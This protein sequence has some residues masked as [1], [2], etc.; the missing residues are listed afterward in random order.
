[1]LASERRGMIKWENIICARRSPKFIFLAASI[2]R[3]KEQ[4][5]QFKGSESIPDYPIFA[6][7]NFRPLTPRTP[8]PPLPL[9]LP[10]PASSNTGSANK[11]GTGS[12]ATLSPSTPAPPRPFTARP[13]TPPT[14]P[15]LLLMLLL[16]LLLLFATLTPETTPPPFPRAPPS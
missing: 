4:L 16:L 14:S 15:L 5:H 11:V 6:A 8:A 13:R 1:M 2:G 7:C 9:T 3:R 12:S 10:P